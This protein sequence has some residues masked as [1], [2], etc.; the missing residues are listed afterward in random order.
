MKRIDIQSQ[1]HGHVW[2]LK[3][4]QEEVDA[5]LQEIA[6]TEHW[7]SP[8]KETVIPARPDVLNEQGEVIHQGNPEQT[9]ITQA[10]YTVTV[11]DVTEQVEQ[12]KAIAK[13]LARMQFGMQIMAELAYRNQKRLSN[14]QITVALILT[15][16]EK[17]AKVQRLL[18]NGSTGLA[19]QALIEAEIPELPVEEKLHFVTKIQQYLASEV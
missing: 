13:N 16:E 3:E 9:I 2:L 19:L 4:T 5:Y 17:L 8:Y 11:S 10:E 12:E 6:S 7:G 14:G 18:L 15:I 1:K